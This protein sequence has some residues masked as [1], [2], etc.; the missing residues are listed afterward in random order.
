MG[1]TDAVRSC[2]RQYA[3]FSGRARRS[4]FWYWQLAL[5]LVYGGL[6]VLFVL[7]LFVGV[8]AVYVV[9]LLL[10]VAYFGTLVPSLAVTWRRLHDRDQSGAYYFIALIPLVGPVLLLIALVSDG[11][12]GP[13]RYGPAPTLTAVGGARGYALAKQGTGQR[14]SPGVGD[15]AG[16]RAPRAL[17]QAPGG[18]RRVARP[19][20]RPPWDEQ[21]LRDV[22]VELGFA[23][24]AD[25]V[26][27]LAR[28]AVLLTRG[29][30]DIRERGASRW[31]GWP[32]LPGAPSGR[33][34]PVGSRSRL[35]F[36][37]TSRTSR[38]SRSSRRAWYRYSPTPGAGCQP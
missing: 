5:L 22:L 33:R 10:L 16:P 23:N 21:G 6:V 2:L 8:G 3:T 13:N 24:Y 11:T 31:G 15:A 26:L 27:D 18:I 9:V 30:G 19:P 37:W 20:V 38:T 25:D 35:S 29:S 17:G 28:P 1:P 34:E 36:R 4:E 32:D 7:A 14:N 12:P